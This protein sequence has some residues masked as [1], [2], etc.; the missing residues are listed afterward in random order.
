MFI[1]NIKKANKN[2]TTI[3]LIYIN[4]KIKKKNSN[5]RST[6]SKIFK[7]I[8]RTRLTSIKVFDTFGPDSIKQNK[9]AQRG[10]ENTT[11]NNKRVMAE[12]KVIRSVLR[13]DVKNNFSIF[14]SVKRKRQDSNLQFLAWQANTLP[15]KLLFQFIF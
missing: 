13:F 3:A 9:N 4:K 6:K 14:Y 5:S 12:K 10:K 2:N 15:I 7:K 8:Q 1:G 11:L